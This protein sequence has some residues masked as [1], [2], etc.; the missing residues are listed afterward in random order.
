MKKATRIGFISLVLATTISTP[1]AAQLEEQET[2]PSTST[3]TAA[4]LRITPRLGI[5]HTTSGGGFDGFTRFEGFVPLLQKPGNNLT[6]IEGRL[7]LDND[8]N[9]GGNILLGY[10]T[11][12]PNSRRIWGGYIGYDN[13]NTGNNT[14]NQIGLGAESL[15]EI[16]DFH[17]NAYLPI[18]DN[19]QEVGDVLIRESFFREN[20]LILDQQRNQEAAMG[21]FD[22][23]AGARIAQ[24]G[25]EGDLRGYGGLYYYNAEGSPETLG[26]RLRLQARPT[27]YLNLGVSL[28]NDDLFGTNLV[29]TVGA[30]FP[31]TRP[32]G[33]ISEEESVVA[34]LG[35]SVQRNNAIVIDHQEEVNEVAA[36]NPETDEP[37]VFQH[38]NLGIAGGDGTFENPVG[39]VQEGLDRTL[40]DGN[41]IVYV[42]P[43]TNSGIPP[44]T[45][46][47]QV[48]VLSTGPVQRLETVESGVV[49]L[50]L[51]G[52]GVL[53]TITPGAEASVT[54][55]NR[56]TLSGFDIP[57]AGTNAIEGTNISTVTIRD[58]A[59]ANST[60]RGILL[61]NVTGEVM[62]TDNS[63]NTTGGTGNSGFILENTAES[64][65]LTI[66]RN[67]IANT[68]NNAINIGLT[69]TAEGTANISDNTLSGNQLNG[70]NV[71]FADTAQGRFTI[72][73]NTISNNG[74]VGIISSMSGN[75]TSTLTIDNNTVSDNGVNGIDIQPQEFTTSTATITNN[76]V[77]GN[78]TIGI[79]SRMLGNSTS[80][81][82]ID[83]NTVSD[84]GTNGIDIQFQ[85]FTTST[86][87]IT[88]NTISNNGAN[89]ISIDSIEFA[90]STATITNNT[91]S[92]NRSDGITTSTEGDS[93]LQLLLEGNT[94][95]DNARFGLSLFAE[96]N[97]KTFAGVRFNTMTGNSGTSDPLFPNGFIAETGTQDNLSPTSTICL[98]L[99]NNTSDNG[100]A[101]N[102]LG[103][104]S[105][106]QADTTANTGAIAVPGLPVEPLGDCPVP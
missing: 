54:M 4:D 25:R 74:S 23:E 34:R 81:L 53:P 21:G 83:N 65:D 77:S 30:T 43:G 106:F 94:A 22:V 75:S 95:T 26:W 84:N 9:L 89:G 35:E 31:G 36:T 47:D 80:T 67:R 72:T 92:G 99:S 73:N 3:E 33:S 71:G 103:S 37:Y 93:S 15:G 66:A 46:P 96:D 17:V 42:Q 12:N 32:Q 18:G 14:F 1:V 90:T 51:S 61:T 57:N 64:V 48:Q 28:Q 85:E 40:S 60:Q 98:N 59:I 63:I 101:L 56:T 16:W 45:I 44:F 70:I 91:V 104:Q 78:G 68:T 2:P 86:A 69:N 19:R 27:D 52:A 97:S 38:V 100:F 79:A 29:F 76:A 8:A 10:R 58:N 11:Y 49:Q 102:R 13:R 7:L 5:G 20:F 62:I 88:N 41:D 39:T 55:G 105:T 24:L 87:T 6:F 82:T 50:P